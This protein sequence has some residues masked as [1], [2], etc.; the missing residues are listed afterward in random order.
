MLHFVF[1]KRKV[2]IYNHICLHLHKESL[3]VMETNK[4]WL[5]LTGDEGHWMY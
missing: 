4:K 3:E 2:E 1:K 5:T